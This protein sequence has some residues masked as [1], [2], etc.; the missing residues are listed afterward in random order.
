MSWETKA[1]SCTGPIDDIYAEVK[2]EFPEVTRKDVR[3][4][5]QK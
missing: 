2:K 5:F 3:F 4:L 1:K